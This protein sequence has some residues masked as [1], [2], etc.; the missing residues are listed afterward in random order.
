MAGAR[1]AIAKGR[2]FQLVDSRLNS[3]KEEYLTQL[4][5]GVPLTDIGTSSGIVY[6]DSVAQHVKQDVFGAWWPNVPLKEELI[7]SA[8]M[9]A[10]RIALAPLKH[11]PPDPPKP[12]VTYWVV[13]LKDFELMVAESEK[14]VTVFLITPKHPEVPL[15]PP[16]ADV[17][18]NLWL[19]APAARV[20]EVKALF[21]QEWKLE[22]PQDLVTGV[23]ALRLKG[24]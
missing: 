23:R 19:V 6:S 11:Q 9:H 14:Q 13:G 8:Y 10:M 21:P 3:L 2:I 7:R 24:Y 17:T 4:E 15:P 12:I 16:P 1:T 18:E 5:K 22:A 20:E